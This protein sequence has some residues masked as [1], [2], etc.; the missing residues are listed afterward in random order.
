[1]VGSIY[2]MSTILSKKEM[3]EEDIKFHY[4]SPAIV[5]K[6]DKDKITMETKITDGKINL[7]GNLISREKPKKADYVLY[8]NPNKPIAIVEAKDNKHSIS[9]GLQQAMTYAKMLD[10]PFAYSSNGDGFF[11]HDFLTGKERELSM[12]EFPTEEELISRYKAESNH[13]EGLSSQEEKII[14]QPYFSSMNSY[15]PRYYQRV[16]VNRTVEQIASGKDRLLLVMATGTGKTYTAFQIAYRLL[17]SGMKRKI[18]YLA[19]RNILV[20]QS[21]QQD[22]A[23]LEKV[24]HKINVSKDDPSTITSHQVYFSLYQQ[25]VGDDDAEHFSELFRPDFFDLIIVDECHRGSAKEESKWRK[26]LEYFSSATQIGMTATPKETKYVSNINYFGEPIYTYSLK[27]GIEDGFLAPFKVINISTDIGEGWRPVKGQRD[28][29]GNLIEDRVYNNTDYDYNIIIEDRTNQVASEITKY[30]KATD[31]MAKTIVFCPTEEAAERMR[32]ALINHNADMVKENP[33]YCVRITGSDDYGKSKLDYFISVSEKYPV[34]ATTSKLLST[35]ADCKMTKLI[36]LDEMI[37]SMT[38]FK[39]IIGR[40]TRLREK[41]GKTHFVVMDFRN[42]SRLFADPEWDGPIEIYDDFD[43]E[44][45]PKGGKRNEGG[46]LTPPNPPAI[47]PIVDRNGCK[48][49]IIHKTVSVYDTNGKLL[50]QESI[51][52]YTKENIRGEYATLDAFIREWRKEPKKDKIQSILLERGIDIEQLKK[53]QAME[54]VD[55]FD[56][57]CHIAFN[58]KPLTRKERAENVKKQDFFSRYNG[59]AKEVL[60]ALLDKYMNK[61]ITEI[62]TTEVLRLDPFM[63]LGKPSKIASYFGGKE[64]YKHAVEELQNAIYN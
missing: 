56:F 18:L 55:D 35:G 26:I 41:E 1:M 33:D 47:K 45:N 61:G 48:V 27:K 51:V 4:I 40:G 57:I 24:I 22:F 25:L 52:D 44:N 32:I 37:G 38:E 62:T 49:E 46:G 20:D 59:V 9:Y 63:K 11:E 19:D 5:S 10:V 42:V 21:I 50:R 14:D 23:P 30:L 2:K 31:R 6:W 15:P 8:L 64:G 28:K 34:I 58:Q 54:E 13:G 36:V 43:P 53:E 16:A 17:Q 7:R 39:Q 29:F 12:D 3:T 60:E